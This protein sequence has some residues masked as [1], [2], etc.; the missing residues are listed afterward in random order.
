[1][2][3][4]EVWGNSTGHTLPR[5]AWNR[6]TLVD[7]TNIGMLLEFD[8]DGTATVTAYKD[9]VRAGVM[10]TGSLRG[11]LYPI[12]WFGR[13]GQGVEFISSNPPHS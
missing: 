4:G 5:T 6:N 11:P 2:W 13:K 3:N 1:M 7:G 8:A 12:V 9:G 10:S